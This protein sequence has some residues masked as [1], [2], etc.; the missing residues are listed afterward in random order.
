[1]G[2]FTNL[3]DWEEEQYLSDLIHKGEI[4]EEE[5][6]RACMPAPKKKG[7]EKRKTD[8][9]FFFLF[10]YIATSIFFICGCDSYPISLKS[11]TV[12]S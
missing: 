2:M 3:P 10:F 5:L 9:V 7:G 4:T 11:S 1:M 6:A 8:L 12:K